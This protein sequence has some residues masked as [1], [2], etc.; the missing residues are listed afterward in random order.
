VKQEVSRGR[1]INSLFCISTAQ[2]LLDDPR[3]QS[4]F[5]L[6]SSSFFSLTSDQIQNAVSIKKKE[7]Q[8]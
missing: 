7:A 6:V 2:V 1:S 4:E 3:M 5:L 8:N